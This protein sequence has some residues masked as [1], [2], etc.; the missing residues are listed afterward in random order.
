MKP[1]KERGLIGSISN[2]FCGYCGIQSNS[3]FNCIEF[4]NYQIPSNPEI[5]VVIGMEAA[6]S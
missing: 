1:K 6:K 2:K 3:I 4:L 5:I